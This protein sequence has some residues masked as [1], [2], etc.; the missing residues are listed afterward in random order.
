M[1]ELDH[2]EGWALKNWHSRTVGLEKTLE[3]PLDS[4][5]IKPV[6][7]KGTVNPKGNQPLIFFERTDAEAEAPILGHLIWRVDSLEKT[8]MLG[9]IEGK[10]R[11]GRQRMRWLDSITD[12]MDMKLSK[13]WEI[14]EDRRSLEHGSPRGHKELD[15]TATEQQNWWKDSLTD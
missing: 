7:P 3:S 10:R 13:L 6:N 8:L 12:S 11:Q 9:K 1:W 2:K 15:M 5:E 4:K 14:V